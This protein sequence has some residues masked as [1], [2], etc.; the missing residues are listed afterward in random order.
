MKYQLD[1]DVIVDHLRGI[2]PLRPNL[3]QGDVY[4]SIIT[5]GELLVEAYKSKQSKRN[6]RLIDSFLIEF[7][8]QILP[9]DERVIKKWSQLKSVLGLK[10]SRLDDIYLFIVASAV[11]ND[12]RLVSN[13]KKH[14]QR[15]P[16]LK[17]V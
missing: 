11:V 1:T 2:K 8:I 6:V 13:N 14:F 12:L 17:L 5:Y 3:F 4:I 7:K 10:G 15:I 16:G 9:V